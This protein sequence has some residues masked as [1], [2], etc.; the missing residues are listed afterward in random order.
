M[1]TQGVGLYW[2]ASENRNA[3]Y[4]VYGSKNKDKIKE[5]AFTGSLVCYLLQL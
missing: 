3:E 5:Y 4:N 1:L 2:F